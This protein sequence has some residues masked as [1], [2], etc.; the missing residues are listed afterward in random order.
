MFRSVKPCK[1]HSSLIMIYYALST[2]LYHMVLYFGAN[3]LIVIK[4]QKKSNQN[5]SRKQKQRLMQNSKQLGVVLFKSQCI[6]SI[7]LSLVKNRDH[8]T[9]NYDSHSVLTRQS[10]HF[11]LL[12]ASLSIYQQDV[13]YSGVKLFKKL[14][15][16]LKQIEKYPNK[17]K[18]ALNNYLLMPCIYNLDKF[19]LMNNVYSYD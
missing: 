15:L 2:P 12:Y 10:K 16:E 7:L 4:L 8:F 3:H 19:F 9:T 11:H 6:F 18:S 17:S 14:P 13:H 5:Y 1:S